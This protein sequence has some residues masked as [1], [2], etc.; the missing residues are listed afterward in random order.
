M[1]SHILPL[2]VA[3]FLPNAIPERLTTGHYHACNYCITLS[4]NFEIIVTMFLYCSCI[5]LLN[6]FNHGIK[7]EEENLWQKKKEKT[8]MCLFSRILSGQ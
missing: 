2:K 4:M 5:I 8:V 3:L 6:S 1:L 7:A